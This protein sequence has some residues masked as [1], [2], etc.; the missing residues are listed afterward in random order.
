MLTFQKTRSLFLKDKIKFI[1]L[2]PT[3]VIAHPRYDRIR[4]YYKKDLIVQL[5]EDDT[6]T[7]TNIKTFKV[8]KVKVINRYTPA[9]LKSKCGQVIMKD[10]FKFFD[11]IRI[12]SKGRTMIPEPDKKRLRG[13][14]CHIC[15]NHWFYCGH[16]LSPKRYN[17]YTKLNNS[18]RETYGY[19]NEDYIRYIRRGVDNG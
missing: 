2:S 17:L 9:C 15:Y 1:R 12:D 3:V 16:K 4:L 13:T 6:Y 7:L 8:N 18:Y 11:G 19:S 10:K 14:D 5:F